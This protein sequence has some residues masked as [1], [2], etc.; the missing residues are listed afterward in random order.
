M[1]VVWSFRT[2]NRMRNGCSVRQWQK[3]FM[4]KMI[5]LVLGRRSRS[6]YFG[7]PRNNGEGSSG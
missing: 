2:L 1:I 3:R 4:E 7:V 6:D 5:V